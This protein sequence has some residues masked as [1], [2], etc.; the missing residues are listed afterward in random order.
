MPDK[1]K[2][3]RVEA[4]ILRHMNYGEADRLLTIFTRNHGKLQTIAK[5][6]RK[7]K[8]RKAGH[9]E[10]F[11]RATL[12]LAR[13]RDLYILTQAEAI[14]VFEN[15][16]ENLILLSYAAYVIELVD[17]S[18][19]DEVEHQAMYR[20]LTQSLARLN[21]GEDPNRVVRYFE[22]RLLD[23]IGFRPQLQHCNICQSTTQ[24]EDQ[25]FSANHGGV[26]C[27][28][29]GQRD[30]QFKSIS[31]LTLKY[32]RHFQRSSYKE[33][34]RASISKAIYSE[35]ET[36]MNYY[37]TYNLERKLNSPIFLHQVRTNQ[38]ET[39]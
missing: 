8:S 29:C 20:L 16:R 36:L 33:A 19:T 26:V 25:F 24:P 34:S 22:I 9:V 30:P 4:V 17:R 11:T 15:L 32:F 38:T 6:I 21:R 10:P 27:P 13:G 1:E 39:K 5:G 7:S 12:Q 3:F 37:I 28:M 23:F 2:S 35:M 31:L 18:T 14:D